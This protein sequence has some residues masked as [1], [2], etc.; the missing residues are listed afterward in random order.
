MIVFDLRCAA[1]GHV[2]EAWFGTSDDYEGQRARGL[3]A[4]PLCGDTDIGKAAMAPRVGAK[5][6]RSDGEAARPVALP[7]ESPGEVKAMLGAMAKMQAAMLEKSSW[8]GRDFADRARAMHHGERATEPIHGEATPAEA[9]A[10]IDEG[11]GVAPLPF[12]VEPPDRRN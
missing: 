4:C 9:E 2:F 3:V 1:A 7:A 5:S 11:I 10:L 8:V 12:P 6:N